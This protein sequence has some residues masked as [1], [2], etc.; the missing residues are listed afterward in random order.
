MLC[1]IA[2]ILPTLQQWLPWII[3]ILTPL[4][5]C[6]AI[7]CGL[8]SRLRDKNNTLTDELRK[9]QEQDA[10]LR[11]TLAELQRMNELKD[12]LIKLF[13]HDISIPIFYMERRMV[14]LVN[15]P[16]ISEECRTKI[17]TLND[18]A[19]QLR[20]LTENLLTWIKAQ[21]KDS[22]L[23]IV[24]EDVNLTEI[25]T[26][27]LK[28]FERRMKEEHIGLEMR[29][30]PDLTI[31]TDRTIFGMILYNLLANSTKSLRNG[32]IVIQGKRIKSTGRLKL[33]MTDI[34]KHAR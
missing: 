11:T 14:T 19:Y 8:Y 2:D 4:M 31:H 20:M 21:Q 12:M 30:P 26:Q 18:T 32:M 1:A 9:L 22:R 13:N 5:M 7:C 17:H 25:L 33:V 15:D 23:N 24:H 6:L 27:H 28:M 10:E 34:P 29:I 3:L 16:R